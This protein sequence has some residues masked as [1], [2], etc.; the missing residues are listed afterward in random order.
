[1]AIDLGL[2]NLIDS[3]KGV[4]ATSLTFASNLV[5]LVE[6][7]LRSDRNPFGGESVIQI[8][9][10]DEEPVGPMQFQLP[11]IPTQ[12]GEVSAALSIVFPDA[13]GGSG[14][15]TYTLTNSDD[16]AINIPGLMFN[17]ATRTLSGTPTETGTHI[18]KYTA[19]DGTDSLSRTFNLEIRV[20][21][22]ALFLPSPGDQIFI[23][24]EEHSVELPAAIGGTA[25]YT[26]ELYLTTPGD[27]LPENGLTFDPATRILSGTPTRSG[28]WVYQY[29]VRDSQNRTAG[30]V[31]FA[32]T[33]ETS[34]VDP[35]ITSIQPS[36][37]WTRTTSLFTVTFSL[38][39]SEWP[40][41]WIFP[42]IPPGFRITVT[43]RI[44]LAGSS[45]G[46]ISMTFSGVTNATLAHE[47]EQ[48]MYII[49][50]RL[51]STTMRER[52]LS[53][54]GPNHPNNTLSDNTAPYGWHPGWNLS[55]F[56]GEHFASGSVWVRLRYDG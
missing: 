47:L 51:G 24:N 10:E 56:F 41:N 6:Q 26:Y 55:T 46:R 35:E 19:S 33:I 42:D 12:Y 36:I 14:N 21:G 27:E 31:S 20:A 4:P 28:E 48:N 23:F 7:G 17:A 18:L 11:T 32:L 44:T 39:G 52:F 43:I 13:S 45:A 22:T 2:D 5:A 15:Y 9:D 1:M 53:C 50:R 30:P 49:F 8:E 25:P 16:T 29:R 34:N 3:L 38:D 40:D 54:R 37:S